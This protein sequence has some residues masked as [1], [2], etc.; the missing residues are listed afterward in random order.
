MDSMQ[1]IQWIVAAVV[2]LAAGYVAIKFG[3]NCVDDV[4][5]TNIGAAFAG[6]AIA[7]VSI[8]SSVKARKTLL[9]T[10]PPA[11]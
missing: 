11:K 9:A 7:G 10:P 2:R 6:L 8:Y 1:T 3:K 4:T 5:W